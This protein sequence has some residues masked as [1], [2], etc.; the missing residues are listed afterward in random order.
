M[1]R[2][3][4]EEAKHTRSLLLDTAEQLFSEKG[5]SNTTLA[6]IANSAG[7]TRG[8]VYWHFTNKLDLYQAMLTR[9]TTQF[10]TLN[11][12]LLIM[13]QANP[14]QALWAHAHQLLVMVQ[15]DVQVR[16]IL[17]I[18]MMCSEQVGELAPIHNECVLHM[19]A[20]LERLIMV[21]KLA[22][23][24]GQTQVHVDPVSAAI[25]LQT[26]YQGLIKRWLIECCNGNCR[27]NPTP[28]LGY[29]YRGIFLPKVLKQLSPCC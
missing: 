15:E 7:L 3:T 9:V 4:R 24:A 22:V 16:R 12:Q 23:R 1:A 19:H 13:A 18:L 20:G 5:V 25:A 26:L 10:D 2:K 6:D 17:L 11:N 29:L 8:A 28:L 14:A 21:M 27:E